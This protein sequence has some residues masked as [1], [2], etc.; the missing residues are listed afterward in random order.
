MQPAARTASLQQ[1]A[2]ILWLAAI[3]LHAADPVIPA[4]RASVAELL[5]ALFRP[6]E[7]PAAGP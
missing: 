2:W 6:P 4:H 3:G 5:R 7:E 1:R